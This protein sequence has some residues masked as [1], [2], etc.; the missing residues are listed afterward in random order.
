[1]IDDVSLQA[2]ESYSVKVLD[3]AAK[4]GVEVVEVGC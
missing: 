1:M 4:G 2:L 3:E